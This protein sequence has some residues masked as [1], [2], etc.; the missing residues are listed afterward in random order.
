VSDLALEFVWLEFSLVAGE[1]PSRGALLGHTGIEGQGDTP[2]RV[3]G[4]EAY[5]ALRRLAW[6]YRAERNDYAS[7]QLDVAMQVVA[8]RV[9]ARPGVVAA[10]V[11]RVVQCLKAD[12]CGCDRCRYGV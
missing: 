12:R 11:D 2:G 5:A 1:G 10:D 4:H 7:A 6:R 3:F 8:D 9:K